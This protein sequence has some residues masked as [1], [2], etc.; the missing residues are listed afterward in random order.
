MSSGS[1]VA[2]ETGEAI[3]E[4]TIVSETQAQ[5]IVRD[6]VVLLFRGTHRRAPDPI[7]SGTTRGRLSPFRPGHLV[8]PGIA[9][10]PDAAHGRRVPD[11][12]VASVPKHPEWLGIR[13]ARQPGRTAKVPLRVRR[14]RLHR[15]NQP[16][17]RP[18]VPAPSPLHAG[19][20]PVHIQGAPIFTACGGCR[21]VATRAKATHVIASTLELDEGPVPRV[22]GRGPRRVMHA[23]LPRLD[24]HLLVAH[25]VVDV[26]QAHRLGLR[27]PHPVG[28]PVVGDARLG[29]DAGA[30]EDRDLLRRAHPGGRL[31]QSVV[32]Q[33]EVHMGSIS[34]F[35][36]GTGLEFSHGLHPRQMGNQPIRRWES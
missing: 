16:D 14:M 17:P 11:L 33:H 27:R 19:T 34:E 4:A 6:T 8:R 20:S 21:W 35:E 30:G 28:P 26:H 25:V 1:D 32:L 10:G 22:R 13:R 2:A 5:R 29:A 3:V 18:P 36:G 7:Y 23:F 15:G 31:G 9:V 12:A 24:A